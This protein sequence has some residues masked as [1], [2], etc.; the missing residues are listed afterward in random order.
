[1]ERYSSFDADI[2]S[3]GAILHGLED[4]APWDLKEE[5]LKA[6]DVSNIDNP[7]YSQPLLAAIQIALVN[8]LAALGVVPDSV[9]GFSSGEKAAAYASGAIT[10]AEAIIAAYYCG[11]VVKQ[12]DQGKGGMAVVGLSYAQV[13]PFLKP[14][15]MVGCDPSPQ[16]TVLS[17]DTEPL[18]RVCEDIRKAKLGVFCFRLPSRVAYHSRMCNYPTTVDHP[19]ISLGSSFH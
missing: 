15:V 19:Q 8:F 12:L 1:M 4:P 11:E 3:L 5:L 17:G 14:G 9:I 13:Q 7:E 6:A 10:A 2:Q 18:D 16:Q